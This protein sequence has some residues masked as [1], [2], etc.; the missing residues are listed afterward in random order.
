MKDVMLR[1][2]EKRFGEIPVLRGVTM[3]LPAGKTT[4]LMG[5]SGCGKTTL[6]RILLG[7]LPPDAGEVIGMPEKKA[8]VFQEDRLLPGFTARE[9]VLFAMRHKDPAAADACLTA[10]GLGEALCRPAAALSGGMCRR[11]AIARALM[12][13]SDFLAMDEPFKGLDGETRASV[14]AYIRARTV[15][16]TL[17]IITHEEEEAALLGAPILH[18]E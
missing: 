11:V 1:G 16:K 14:V 17:L 5:R 15:G 7:I 10:L 8:A 18:L 13:E 9:N 3:T 2:I 4:C 12:A 6:F